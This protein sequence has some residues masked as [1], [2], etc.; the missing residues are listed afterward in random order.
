[1]KGA[2][3]DDLIVGCGKGAITVEAVGVAP[4]VKNASFTYS[5]PARSSNRT[6]SFHMKITG[7][8]SDKGKKVKGTA[9][10]ASV[11]RTGSYT[12]SKSPAA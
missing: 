9:S 8:F 11:C 12:A 4:K 2:H 7:T 5:G 3:V 10:T 6:N 1:V